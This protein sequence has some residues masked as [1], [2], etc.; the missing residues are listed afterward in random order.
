MVVIRAFG[1]PARV[2]TSGLVYPWKR[3]TILQ[4]ML[5]FV[6]RVDKNLSFSYYL[7]CANL[8]LSLRLELLSALLVGATGLILLAD[9]DAIDASIAGF[10]LTFALCIS[11]EM[12]SIVAS[13]T[14]GKGTKL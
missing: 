11:N 3:L 7:W 13:D 12:L 9:A 6:Q 2:S 5:T 8:W 4:F 10:A 1:A 14:S